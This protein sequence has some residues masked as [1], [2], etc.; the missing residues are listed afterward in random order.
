MALPPFDAECFLI[1]PI[2]ERGGE[3][4]D[5]AD[6]VRDFIVAPAVTDLGLTAVRADAIAE[7]GQITLQVIE[8][9]LKAK[10]AVA[11]LTGPNAN[12]FYE[13]AIRHTAQL[14]VV[15]IAHE[16][17][18]GNLPFDI[19][20]MRTIFYDHKSLKSAA[21]CR[22]A[23]T[24]QLGQ[25]LAKGT[26][27]SPVAAS[28]NLANLQGGDASEQGIAR[29]MDAVER[30]MRDQ[31]DIGGMVAGISNRLEG[32]D[33]NRK[34]SPGIEAIA[35]K[36]ASDFAERQQVADDIKDLLPDAI[37]GLDPTQATVFL[38]LTATPPKESL[39]RVVELADA[40]NL[41]V[42]VSIAPVPGRPAVRRLE[43]Q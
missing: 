17:Q 29:V 4:R 34:L 30:I 23:I 35:K 31:S 33:R 13:L 37:V 19:A 2:G 3:T 1:S 43:G 15:L 10:G 41:S 21:D 6:G 25:A 18:R 40:K 9:V 24:E 8:H 38:V 39:D 28:V 14:P 11:D 20:Q 16:E 32:M 42:S 7:P 36:I 22:A 5:R 26:V 27:D 12:V